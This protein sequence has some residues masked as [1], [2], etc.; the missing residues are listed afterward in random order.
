MW[1][2]LQWS[3]LSGY[4]QSDLKKFISVKLSSTYF[5]SNLN[6]MWFAYSVY[7]IF[8]I[9][10]FITPP[11]IFPI[12]VYHK[13]FKHIYKFLW[14]YLNVNKTTEILE[15]EIVISSPLSLCFLRRR[16]KLQLA[17][18]STFLILISV[19]LVLGR[20]TYRNIEIIIEILITNN[21]PPKLY[22]DS[23]NRKTMESIII[24]RG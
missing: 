7:Y 6:Y 13:I 10:T 16:G 24:V 8:F 1:N 18:T 4:L 20:I 12:A 5:D 2:V 15:F 23:N 19:I 17:Y 14:I 3:W 11:Y 22:S 9:V 21:S